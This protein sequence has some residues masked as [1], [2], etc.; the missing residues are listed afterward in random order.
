[1]LTFI[2]YNISNSLNILITWISISTQPYLDHDRQHCGSGDAGGSDA[3]VGIRSRIVASSSLLLNKNS[4]REWEEGEQSGRRELRWGPILTNRLTIPS[5]CS[6]LCSNSCFCSNSWLYLSACSYWWIC[7]EDHPY[8]FCLCWS[9]TF[10]ST[11]SCFSSSSPLLMDLFLHLSL[12][13]F[14]IRIRQDGSRQK[15][16]PQPRQ[17]NKLNTVGPSLT[18]LVAKYFFSSTLQRLLPAGQLGFTSA[19]AWRH[20]GGRICNGEYLSI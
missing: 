18:L 7:S 9:W 12:S 2:P 13:Q 20:W 11:R 5:S 10:P 8:Q 19:A 17:V 15:W 4:H 1:M 6:Y 3:K 16:R 14:K